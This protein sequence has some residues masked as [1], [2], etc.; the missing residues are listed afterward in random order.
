MRKTRIS[1]KSLPLYCYLIHWESVFFLFSYILFFCLL[2][3]FFVLYYLIPVVRLPTVL[4][5]Q[6]LWPHI[7][8]F[9]EL[10]HFISYIFPDK[11]IFNTIIQYYSKQ[12]DWQCITFSCC[13]ININI[14]VILF[15]ITTFASESSCVIIIKFMPLLGNFLVVIFLSF[16]S[17]NSIKCLLKIYKQYFYLI[18]H[19][20]AFSIICI[21]ISIS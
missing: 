4:D 6:I 12:Y 15:S 17:M 2:I 1:F 11:C 16:L 14:S 19:S 18:L 10:Y 5:S 7:P 13:Y 9:I 8:I 20:Y 3:L 21:K